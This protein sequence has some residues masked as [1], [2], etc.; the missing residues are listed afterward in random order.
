MGGVIGALVVGLMLVVFLLLNNRNTN[1]GAGNPAPIDT[2]V[3]AG[4]ATAAGDTPPRMPMDQF[5]ALY[6]D[7]AKRPIILD[8][9]AKDTF[10]A[11]HI[12]GAESFPEAD[13]DTRVSELP[14]DKLI[15]AYC[16]WPAENESARVA[17]KLHDTYGFSYD[18]LKV[19]LGGWNSWLQQN[20]TDP[21]GYPI[22]VDATATPGGPVPTKGGSGSVVT[23]TIVLA[24]QAP[25]KQ[26]TPWRINL[27]D[28]CPHGGWE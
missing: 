10:D 13:V 20:S 26:T 28:N 14:K 23:A 2:S 6:D 24:P 21:K 18:N 12:T 27:K 17:Q 15:V 19:L 11:G 16:Q 5:K 3:A 4:A 9:R 22:T 25:A 7:P 8:V 1:G